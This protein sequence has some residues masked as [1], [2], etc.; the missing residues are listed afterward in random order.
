LAPR[1]ELEIELLRYLLT[2]FEHAS[3][4]RVLSGPGLFNI[5]KFLRDTGRGEE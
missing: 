4:E 5:Y 1:N 2:Q 3:Y